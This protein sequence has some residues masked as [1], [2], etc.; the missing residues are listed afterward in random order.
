MNKKVCCTCEVVVLLIK[1]IVFLTF[2]LSSASLDLKVP[3][4]RDELQYTVETSRSFGY[5]TIVIQKVNETL[6]PSY[7]SYLNLITP[8]PTFN[9]YEVI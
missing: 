9:I 6:N 7:I 2:L 1:P 5:V 3:I 8:S 4:D